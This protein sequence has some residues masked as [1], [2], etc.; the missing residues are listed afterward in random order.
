MDLLVAALAGRLLEAEEGQEAAVSPQAKA[1]GPLETDKTMR[2]K[3]SLLLM[4]TRDPVRRLTFKR[5]ST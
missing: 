1:A 5:L 3:S 4:L 2:T